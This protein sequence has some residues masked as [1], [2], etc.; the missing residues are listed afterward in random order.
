M[1]WADDRRRRQELRGIL[2]E[3][4][5]ITRNY[6]G[7][8]DF[9]ILGERLDSIGVEV[10]RN[11]TRGSWVYGAL[12]ALVVICIIGSTLGL[13]KW[14]RRGPELKEKSGDAWVTRSSGALVRRQPIFGSERLYD[15][16]EGDRVNILEMPKSRQEKTWVKVQ[17]VK[18]DKVFHPGFVQI[19]HLTFGPAIE[20]RWLEALRPN[21]GAA[22]Q[23]LQNYA[24]Q[25]DPIATDNQVSNARVRALLSQAEIEVE[26]ARRSRERGDP[27]Q[28]W[29]PK[30]ERATE[31]LNKVEGLL[32]GVDQPVQYTSR[33]QSVASLLNGLTPRP[34]EPNHSEVVVSHDSVPTLQKAFGAA[35]ATAQDATD[36]G[37]Y[38][39]AFL[40][41]Q[42]FVSNP[43]GRKEAEKV[44]DLIKREL[45]LGSIE[46]EAVR[47][48]RSK[49]KGSARKILDDATKEVID[50]KSGR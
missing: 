23:T 11:K 18:S 17:Y 26:L 21:L 45:N 28:D 42:N 44:A 15:I 47:Q 46:V 1:K 14:V 24:L 40:A 48:L 22:D 39:K 29:I 4:R 32:K 7:D 34:S 41:I 35:L 33:L 19:E 12:A 9:T 50:S 10:L 38:T 8:S 31:K 43:E 2:D 5:N 3:G 13:M 20:L 36:R 6:P 25:L 30:K 16:P 27:D 49:L 37:D